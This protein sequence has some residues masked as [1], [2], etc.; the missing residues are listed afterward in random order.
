VFSVQLINFLGYDVLFQDVDMV[1]F[2]NPLD[3]F[4][5]PK[6]EVANFDIIFQDDGA[7]SVRFAP[8]SA[9]SGFYYVRSNLR[10]QNMLV[11]LL[12]A[13]DRVIQ[14]SSHQQALT[15]VLNE[16]ASLYGL[17]VKV[18]ERDRPDFPCGYHFHQRKQFMK[19]LLAGKTNTYIFHMSWTTN[20]VNKLK[21]FQ[22]IGQWYVQDTC[23]GKT[24]QEIDP[25]ITTIGDKTKGSLLNQCCIAT[26][27]VKCHYKDKPSLIPCADSPNIDKFGRPFW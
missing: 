12:E 23:P 3:Y 1:W 4:Q 7:H 15:S 22:Q 5:D 19:D 26:P 14:S 27:V 10:T 9:N 25:T 8:Y 2:K 20:K 17:K 24:V 13:G 21:Y 16:H 6:S 11:A 18:L